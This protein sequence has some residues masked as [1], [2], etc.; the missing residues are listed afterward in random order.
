MVLRLYYQYDPS[1][2]SACPLTVHSL[3]HIA[4]SIQFL[5]PV[6]TYWAFPME[7]FCGRLKHVVTSRRFP[8][9]RLDNH[10]CAIAHLDTV[11]MLYNLEETIFLFPR[12]EPQLLANR[13]LVH[14]DCMF[15]YL[16]HFFV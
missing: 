15:F 12:P 2:M 13:N 3:L 1:R 9:A 11:W 4:D 8:W 5:G 16:S 6:W 14:P 7:R 10:V